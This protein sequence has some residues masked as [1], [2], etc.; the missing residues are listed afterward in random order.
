ME[1]YFTSGKKT[2]GDK[3]TIEGDDFKHLSKVLRKKK[4]ELIWVTDGEKN[5]YKAEIV[6]LDKDSIK[7][8]ILEKSYNV[9]E[10]EI[11]VTLYQSLLKNP[12]RF[13]FVL[14]KSV[15]LGVYE[16]NPIITEY[17]I[18]KKSNK[19]NR[20]QSIALAAM[21]QSQRCYLPKVNHPI[22]F[23]EALSL[24]G[25]DDLKITA[26]ERIFPNTMYADELKSIIRKNRGIAVFI[27]PEGGFTDEEIES[28]VKAGFITLNLGDRKYRSETAAIALLSIILIK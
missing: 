11:K 3:L 9:N 26:D 21:K 24:P 17:V 22:N 23:A 16:I 5:L 18:N 10:P 20:W 27:G 25:K 7:C 14:E 2:A 12:A 19:T 13:E 15:E 4:G 28:A 1:Y 8:R 6:S